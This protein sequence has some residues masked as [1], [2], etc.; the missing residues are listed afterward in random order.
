MLLLFSILLRAYYITDTDTG[1]VLGQRG[2]DKI[3]HDSHLLPFG[4]LRWTAQNHNHQWFDW[5]RLQTFCFNWVLVLHFAHRI[6]SP[7]S[8]PACS[9]ASCMKQATPPWS[10]L[11]TFLRSFFFF[12][13]G[14]PWLFFFFLHIVCSHK[15]MNIF[16]MEWF[17]S[18]LKDLIL[19]FF[20]IFCVLWKMLLHC[21]RHSPCFQFNKWAKRE[22]N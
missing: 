6:I 13:F 20:L 7:H 10:S 19:C 17:S 14:S 1:A 4:F 21:I 8:V 16:P 18:I 15:H 12:N 5:L 11:Y 2:R 22:K 9:Y 3:I